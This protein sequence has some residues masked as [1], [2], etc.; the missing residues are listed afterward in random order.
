MRHYY[1]RSYNVAVVIKMLI[2]GVIG[3]KKYLI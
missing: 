3:L 1:R 2:Y